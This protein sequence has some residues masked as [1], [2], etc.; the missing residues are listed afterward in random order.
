MKYLRLSNNQLKILAVLSMLADHV[1]KELFPQLEFLQIFGRLA[2]PIFAFM[3][4]E[5]CFYTR[6]KR[7][8]FLK[9]AGLA[10]GCQLVYFI[11]EK[12]YYQ[13][14]LVTFSLSI[15]TIFAIDNFIK[16]KNLSSA[17]LVA[18]D[19]S[20]VI[21]LCLGMPVLVKGFQIDYGFSGLLLPVIVYF[22]PKKP[23]KLVAAFVMLVFLSIDL[24]GI[25]WY[26]LLSLVPIALYNG[27]RGRLKLKYLFYVFYPL[28]LAVIYL[29]KILFF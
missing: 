7:Q 8:Y 3:I 29:I 1:G 17:L 26:S 2:F 25:Q 6:K 10:V 22:A 12:S 19:A 13:N 28:H 23:L 9:I 20:A 14:V 5:G 21:F 16:K 27:K 15:L 24:G 11:A 18:I 4:A